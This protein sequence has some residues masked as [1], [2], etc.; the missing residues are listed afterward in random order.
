[1]KV[2]F[3]DLASKLM[4]DQKSFF[5]YIKKNNVK[6]RK[7]KG[8]SELNDA[9]RKAT[10]NGMGKVEYELDMLELYLQDVF[11]KN[12]TPRNQENQDS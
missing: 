9:M 8:N 11:L 6:F 2:D 5:K 10:K 4:F 3:K 1:M 7:G 12:C